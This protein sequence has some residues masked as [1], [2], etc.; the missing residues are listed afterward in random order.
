MASEPV[1]QALFLGAGA[2]M[3]CGVGQFTHLLCEAVEE[4]DPGSC[5]TLTLARSEGS[6]ADIWR[7]V[8]SARNVVCNFPI[9]AWKRV[10]FRAAAIGLLI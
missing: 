4:F 7:A 3:R 8:A 2:Q 6:L 5:T 9:V 10:M 1:Y